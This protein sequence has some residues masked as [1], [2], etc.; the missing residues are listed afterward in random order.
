MYGHLLQSMEECLPDGKA[1]RSTNNGVKWEEVSAGLNDIPIEAERCGGNI[2]AGTFQ[3]MYL[4]TDNG[5][6]W[7]SPEGE[8]TD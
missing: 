7:S 4:S 3:G 1:Y 8:L 5:N 6:S 2:L